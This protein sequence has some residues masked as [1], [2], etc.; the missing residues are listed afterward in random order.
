MQQGVR[1]AVG[2]PVSNIIKDIKK[3][4]YNPETVPPEFMRLDKSVAPIIGNLIASQ[5]P[6]ETNTIGKQL[7]QGSVQ[8][9]EGPLVD[10]DPNLVTGIRQRPHEP[11]SEEH[12]SE[13]QSQSNL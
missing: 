8:R 11:R 12:T 2:R 7:E 3:L 10:M 9:P 6:F 1:G 5:L 13:L 4:Y